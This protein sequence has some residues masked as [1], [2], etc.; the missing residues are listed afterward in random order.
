MT[1][2]KDVARFIAGVIPNKNFRGKTIEIIGPSS[3]S[4][5]EVAASFGKIF[6]KKVEVYPIPEE[7]WESMLKQV[8]FSDNATDN[9]IKMIKAVIEGKAAPEN[10]DIVKMKIDLS[11]YLSDKNL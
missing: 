1:S 3:Y 11:T 2:P 7:N 5:F 4:S 9:M 10:D 6:N 8:G